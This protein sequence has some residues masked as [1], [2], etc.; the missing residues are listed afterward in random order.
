VVDEEV[1]AV[2]AEPQVAAGLHDG[3]PPSGEGLGPV[4]APAG[5]DQLAGAGGSAPGVGD[6][7]VEVARVGGSAA[8]GEAAVGAESR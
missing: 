6:G 5:R 2:R 1:P 7:M 3:V 8:P 4:V